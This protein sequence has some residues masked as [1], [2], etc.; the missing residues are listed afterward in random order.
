MAYT[1]KSEVLHEEKNQRGMTWEQFS[2]WVTPDGNKDR[3]KNCV[4]KNYPVKNEEAQAI[5]ARLGKSIEDIA[6]ETEPS[7]TESIKEQ[8]DRIEAKLDRFL[9]LFDVEGKDDQT[10]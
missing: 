1:L 5:A 10:D 6:E 4:Y 7:Q 8:L 9:G 3:I 2:I